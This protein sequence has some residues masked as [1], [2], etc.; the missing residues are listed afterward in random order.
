[1]A[2][3]I[4]YQGRGLG[5]LALSDACAVATAWPTD[6]IRLDAYDAEPGAGPFFA[7]CGFQERG[8]LV[9]KGNPLRYYELFLR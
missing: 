2:V 8:R 9:Y 1:M 7:G 3:S 6:A 4:A 5:R